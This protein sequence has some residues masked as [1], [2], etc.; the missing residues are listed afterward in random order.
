VTA[1]ANVVEWGIST[2]VERRIVCA[3]I[4]FCLDQGDTEWWLQQMVLSW[5]IADKI[6]TLSFQI[7]VIDE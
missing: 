4:S 7:K 1:I 2:A 5:I 3:T 6:S